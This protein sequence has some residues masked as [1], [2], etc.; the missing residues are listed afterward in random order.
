MPIAEVSIV[1]IGTSTT[2]VSEYVARALRVLTKQEAVAYE[3]TSMG[4]II[5]GELDDIFTAI[6]AMHESIFDEK[7]HR[8]YTRIV[9][10]DR[11]DKLMSIS[12]KV[13]SV[14]KKMR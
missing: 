5:Q 12:E 7:V 8:V 3:L 14:Q 1:P 9:I 10:D 6:K 2:S 11:R 13:G 4:T